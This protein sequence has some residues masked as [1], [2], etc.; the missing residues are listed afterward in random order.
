MHTMTWIT[1][2]VGIVC[3]G[4]FFQWL[5]VKEDD[6]AHRIADLEHEIEMLRKELKNKK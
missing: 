2:I 4:A 5:F 1:L 3:L 6:Y